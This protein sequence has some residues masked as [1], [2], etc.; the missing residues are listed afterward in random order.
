M[1]ILGLLF[2]VAVLMIGFYLI[3]TSARMRKRRL[4]MDD[5][6]PA[7][8]EMVI[9]EFRGKE[10]PMTYLQKLEVWDYMSDK[11]KKNMVKAMDKAIER[12]KATPKKFGRVS[13]QCKVYTE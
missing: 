2:I 8:D 9:V 6:T 12:G 1:E 3:R 7:M 4:S 10:V 13:H 5:D 11:Q